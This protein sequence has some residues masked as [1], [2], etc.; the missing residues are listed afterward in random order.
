MLSGLQGFASGRISRASS[1]PTADLTIRRLAAIEALSRYGRAQADLLST[2][3]I[4]PNLWPTST[5]IDWDNIL[6]RVPDVRD[7]QA[8]L[9]E[10]DQILRSRLNFQGTTMGFS[11]ERMDAMWWLMVSADTNAVR[12]LISRLNSAAWKQDIPRLVRGA[13]GRQRRGH[14]DTTVANAWGVLA[15]EKFSVAFESTPVTGESSATLAGGTQVVDWQATP[16]G[17]A[18]SFPWPGQRSTLELGMRGTGM[19]WATIQSLAAV[20]LLEPLSSGFT[21]RRAL[22]PV[23]RREQ[24]AWSA[25][26]I[27][28]V[29]LEIES[30]AD[31]TWVVVNDPIPAGSAIF[32]TGL[33][34]DS[35]LATRGEEN[36]GWVWPAF[37]ERSLEAYRAYY[38]FVPKGSWTIE[39]TIRLNNA[40]LFQLPPTRV[41]A[42]YAPE[43]FGEIPNAPMQI[44]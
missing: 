40:G 36:K 2:I 28:R 18:L 24:G 25:G 42:M 15:M 41:E 26:D 33:G 43:M 8:R 17:D 23:D 32:G 16:K 13:L 4:D 6:T 20:P 9:T 22:V 31:M 44:R 19:P 39:Y 29:R 5:I 21:V 7:R 14:W 10:A 35:R 1:L 37:E 30:Q 27:V 12:L 11:T 38:Q 3:P 34:S